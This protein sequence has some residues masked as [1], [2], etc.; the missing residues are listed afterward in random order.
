MLRGRLLPRFQGQ[1]ALFGTQEIGA[2]PRMSL[3]SVLFP[4]RRRLAGSY[5][6]QIEQKHD[7]KSLDTH[8]VG[9]QEDERFRKGTK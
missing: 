7:D 2:R 9:E 6:G 3:L 1:G 5:E 8:W 4:E